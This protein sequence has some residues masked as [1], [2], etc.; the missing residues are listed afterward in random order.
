MSMKIRE[1]GEFALL[2]RLCRIIALPGG[3]VIIGIGDDAALWKGS[4][5]ALA[6]TDSLVAGV[7]F[8]MDDLS[9]REVGSK[10]ILVNVSDVA[11]MG[12]IPKYA[13]ISLSLSPEM[14]LCE[15]EELYEG[16]SEACSA[17]GISVVGG[18]LSSC[19][20]LVVNVTLIGEAKDEKVLTR[21]GAKA[22][23]LVAVTGYLGLAGGYRRLKSDIHNLDP[24]IQVILRQA[25]ACPNARILEGR[26]LCELGVRAAIDISDGLVRD[27]SHICEESHLGAMIM[28]DR[29]PLHPEAREILTAEDALYGGEDYELLFTAPPGLIPTLEQRLPCP[30]TVVGKMVEDHPGEIILLD[31][32]ENRLPH[33]TSGWDHFA[34]PNLKP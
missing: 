2:D 30:V 18:N 34:H 9:F 32:K 7:H 19:P 25:F 8:F 16:I 26:L 12:G 4:S 27:L 6:T 20:T 31:G 29:L 1:V 13:L 17:L 23:D 11:A 24:K 28:V 21:R 14:E 10:S 33:L 22:R 15:V 5:F 3:E